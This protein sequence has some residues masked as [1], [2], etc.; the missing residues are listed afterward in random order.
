MSVSPE[1]IMPVGFNEDVY[2]LVVMVG[3]KLAA[4]VNGSFDFLKLIVLTVSRR[5]KALLQPEGHLSLFLAILLILIH[6]SYFSFI[7]IFSYHSRSS[8]PQV[9]SIN[10]IIFGAFGTVLSFFK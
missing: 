9:V 10:L 7:V 2:W 1:S 6:M 8:E 5:H 4:L 3:L